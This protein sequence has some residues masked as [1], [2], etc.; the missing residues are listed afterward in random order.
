MVIDLEAAYFNKH[1]RTVIAVALQPNLTLDVDYQ[2]YFETVGQ[3]TT[4]FIVSW[5]VAN[6]SDRRKRAGFEALAEAVGE[7][8]VQQSLFDAQW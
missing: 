2:P 3:S 1:W 8:L 4:E 5:L 6:A 7:E